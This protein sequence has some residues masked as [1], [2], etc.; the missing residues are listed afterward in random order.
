MSSSRAFR[1]SAPLVAIGA[2][3]WGTDPLFR[4]PLATHF[5][6][7]TVVLGEHLVLFPFALAMAAPTLGKLRRLTLWDWGSLLAIAWGASAL[8]TALFTTAF[9]A[10]TPITAILLQK[11]QPLFALMGARLVLGERL[12]PR[13]ALY[14]LP[15][16]A[17]SYLVSFG[18][19]APANLTASSLVGPVCAMTAAALWGMGTVFGRHLM[20]RLTFR[21]MTA[22]RFLFALP[23]LVV[24]NAA[25]GGVRQVGHLSAAGGSVVALALLPGL[26]SLLLYY[27]G[28][29]GVQASVATLLELAYPA[30]GVLVGYL[31]LHERVDA[32]QAL[33]FA[34]IWLMAGLL[35][36][37]KPVPVK[38]VAGA[39]A[40]LGATSAG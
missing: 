5:A 32:G 22:Y 7:V 4:L 14:V 34:L 8:A 15:C 18:F 31:A 24:L 35:S 29:A 39:T 25:L 36:R 1:L 19:A 38:T 17:G 13:F 40:P 28:L 23:F 11:L 3:L 37:Q 12:P 6:S 10:A 9:A 26:V 20:S 30:T 2:A 16:L 33:G 27:R 21:E